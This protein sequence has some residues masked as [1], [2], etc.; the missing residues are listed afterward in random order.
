MDEQTKIFRR[1][2]GY[3]IIITVGATYV[4]TLLVVG[5]LMNITTVSMTMAQ[6]I[7]LCIATITGFTVWNILKKNEQTKDEQK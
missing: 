6:L 4:L 7:R 5:I 2:L 3:T 1:R